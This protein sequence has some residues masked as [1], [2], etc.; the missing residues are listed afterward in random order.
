M[1]HWFISYSHKDKKIVED[2]Q[3]KLA[4]DDVLIWTDHQIEAGGDWRKLIDLAIDESVGIILIVSSNSMASSFVLYEWSFAMGKGKK[5]IPLSIDETR[6]YSHGIHPKLE[7]IQWIVMQKDPINWS[8][9]ILQSI[10]TVTVSDTEPPTIVQR[11][12]KMFDG[13]EIEDWIKGAY[14]LETNRS[15]S[16]TE[17]LV[18][19][20]NH[21]MF[22][23]RGI[24]AIAL[25]RKSDF[26]N[27][28][29][30]PVFLELLTNNINHKGYWDRGQEFALEFLSQN[31]VSNAEDALVKYVVD[32]TSNI[33]EV[34]LIAKCIKTNFSDTG[35]QRMLSYL[36]HNRHKNKNFETLIHLVD[37]S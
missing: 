11:A 25:A 17:A 26:T 30:G 12:V 29:C 5:I 24:C 19:A 1:S 8:D 36:W 20:C 10:K 37:R 16:A 6:P 35:I 31:A 14:L 18:E 15:A 23:I 4:D 13:L 32:N 21:D 3:Q 28:N 27:P 9:Q 7:P 22:D 34:E 33:D 2:L